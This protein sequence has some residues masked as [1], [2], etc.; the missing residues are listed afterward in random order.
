M[1]ASYFLLNFDWELLPQ[2][3]ICV[4]AGAPRVCLQSFQTI[5]NQRLNELEKLDKATFCRI[6]LNEDVVVRE[7]EIHICV[8]CFS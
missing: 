2:K 5:V 3:L 8:F 1:A 4:T 7:K 6:V